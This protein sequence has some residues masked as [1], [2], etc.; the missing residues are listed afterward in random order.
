MRDLQRLCTICTDKGHCVQE[1]PNGT[2][3]ENLRH[4]CP[5]AFTLDALFNIRGPARDTER[6]DVPFTIR[7]H[8]GSEHY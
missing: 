3:T 2:A 1:L 7:P 5:N 8:A 4:F 6:F